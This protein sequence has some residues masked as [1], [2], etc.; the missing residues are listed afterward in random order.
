MC[1]RRSLLPR[2][3][4]VPV[5]THTYV[6]VCQRVRHVLVQGEHPVENF[7]LAIFFIQ[8]KRNELILIVKKYI[9]YINKY[10]RGHSSLV[11]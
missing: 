10:E 1:S 3:H 11:T 8:S 5:G 6:Y 7:L 2:D 9:L 4:R